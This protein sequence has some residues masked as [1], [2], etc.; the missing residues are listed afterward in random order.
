[1]KQVSI[2]EYFYCDASNFK[3]WGSVLL[4]GKVDATAL[5]RLK[6]RFESEEFFVAE[7]LGLPPLYGELWEL[8]EGPSDADHVW[9]TFHALRTASASEIDRPIFATLEEFVLRADAV[10]QW[11]EELSPHWSSPGGLVAI[12]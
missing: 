9:H 10:T 4:A 11:D 6:C 8:S 2:F 3:S 7:Q 12:D 1:M 5:A